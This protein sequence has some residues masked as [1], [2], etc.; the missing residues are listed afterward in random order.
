[1]IFAAIIN[2]FIRHAY[3]F[4]DDAAGYICPDSTYSVVGYKFDPNTGKLA[5]DSWC[6]TVSM[7]KATASTLVS[8]YID[9][10]GSVR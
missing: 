3:N 9:L 1:Y 7:G 4:A 8:E 6:L 10:V 5:D 2:K